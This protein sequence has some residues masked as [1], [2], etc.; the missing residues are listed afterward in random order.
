MKSSFR[1]Q[2]ILYRRYLTISHHETDILNCETDQ[3]N[4]VFEKLKGLLGSLA[5][6]Q[7]LES[8][9]YLDPVYT[10]MDVIDCLYSSSDNNVNISYI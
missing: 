4:I 3:Q 8:S 2:K 6:I 1:K 7:P 10:R 9:L 5:Y